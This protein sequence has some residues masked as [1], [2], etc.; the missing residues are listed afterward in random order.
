MYIGIIAQNSSILKLFPSPGRDTVR[1]ISPRGTSPGE[2][3]TNQGCLFGNVTASLPILPDREAQDIVLEVVSLL[4]SPGCDV[5]SPYPT[6][7]PVNPIA[8]TT[9]PSLWL[10]YLLAHDR[11]GLERE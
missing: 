11:M 3:D 1:C 7:F 10:E 5:F 2:L 4:G 9:A 6:G 8:L